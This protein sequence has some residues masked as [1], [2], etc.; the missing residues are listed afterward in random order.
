MSKETFRAMSMNL[1]EFMTNDND[2]LNA[3]PSKDRMNKTGSTVKLLGLKWD[4][5]SDTLYIHIK[6]SPTEVLTKRTALKSFASTFDPVGL[7]APLLVRAKI[8]I[9]GSRIRSSAFSDASRRVCAAVTYLLCKAPRENP[10]SNMIFSK[11]K[12][13]VPKKSTI[14]RQELL[15]LVPAIKSTQYLLKELKIPINTIHI[16]SDSQIILHWITSTKP[17]KT[18][19][20]NRVRYIKEL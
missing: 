19:V 4:T 2:V 14:P 13:A 5:S 11:T 10:V 17:L 15:A 12:L 6:T 3:I 20:H 16:F 1:R 7:L 9:K 18:F 8:Q